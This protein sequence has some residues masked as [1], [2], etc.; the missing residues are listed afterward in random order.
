MKHTLTAD[1]ADF[2]NVGKSVDPGESADDRSDFV[3]EG[4]SVEALSL[5]DGKRLVLTGVVD[6]LVTG[7]VVDAPDE[8][9]DETDAPAKSANKAEWVDYAVSQGADPSEAESSTKDELVAAY[10]G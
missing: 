5:P 9:P 6:G 4:D 7:V 2:F 1:E 8:T 10:G 3:K